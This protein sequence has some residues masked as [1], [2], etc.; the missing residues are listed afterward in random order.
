MSKCKLIWVWELVF[1]MKRRDFVKVASASLFSLPFAACSTDKTIPTPIVQLDSGKIRGSFIDGVYRYLGI[2]YAEPPFGENRFRPAVTR[3][4]WEGVFE[5]NQYGEICPQTGGGGLDGG[6]REGEDCLNLNVWTPDP[7]AKGLP[8]MVWVHGGGQ[9][10]GSGSEALSDGTH[11]AKEGVV[12]ISNN[13]RLGAEGYLYLEEL[14]GDGIG[15]GNLG[16]LDQ[17]EVL[18]WVQRNAS[19]FG[20]DPNNVTLFGISGGGAA[21]QALVA[22]EGSKDLVHK[23]IPQSGGHSA[24]RRESAGQISEF[25]LRKIGIKPGDIDSLQKTPWRIFPEIYGDIEAQGLGSP[26]AYLP[27]ISESM[28]IH[29]V[30]AT[31][32]G[33]GSDIDYLTGTCLDEGSL[34]NA[35]GVSPF[36]SR[37]EQL[38]T[39]FSIKKEDL[40][41]SYLSA[42]PELNFE[43]AATTMS[44]DM[45]FRAPTIRI[46]EGHTARSKARTFMYLFTW[47]SQFLGATHA[48][49]GVV[50]GNGVPFGFLAGFNSP[51][52]VSQQMRKSWINF[53]K[54]G[55]PSFDSFR[56][57]E[58]EQTY[59]FTASINDNFSL[60]T[61]PYSKQRALLEPVLTA[62]WLDSGL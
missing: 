44:A 4:A 7:T 40:L 23:V 58:Y 57:P 14:F 15:P 34:F 13:R 53:A 22:T 26:Q 46:A 37:S 39:K 38:L 28:P 56:W 33:I 16:I 29:P 12:F 10:S 2:P 24:Q 5:A 27:M 30:D 32:A 51:D 60:L 6:L 43:E 8:I 61:D 31:Y 19:K 35:L 20:G 3:V 48:M 17:I 47:E 21:I 59:R 11:F 62:N 55:D 41:Q 36:E 42:R 52:K 49:D 18:R 25:T 9:I 54:Y 45:W 50:F 1:A